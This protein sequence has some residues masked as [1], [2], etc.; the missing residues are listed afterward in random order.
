M[1]LAKIILSEEDK[2]LTDNVS[3][4]KGWIHMPHALNDDDD[5]NEI[6]AYKYTKF[7][8]SSFSNS[9]DI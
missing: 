4:L 6:M 1:V 8:D 5:D 3:S 7:D 2:A 9:R